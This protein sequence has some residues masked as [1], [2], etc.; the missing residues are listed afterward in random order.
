MMSNLETM[1][2][3]QSKQEHDVGMNRHIMIGVLQPSQL[4][5]QFPPTPAM[6]VLL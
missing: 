2:T 1:R 3:G 6:T 5:L 4:V